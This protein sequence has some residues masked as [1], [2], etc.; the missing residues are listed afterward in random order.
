[1]HAMPNSLV[2][3]QAS[4]LTVRVPQRTLI[5][6][7][8]WQVMRGQ[9]WCL[10]GR[11]GAGKSSLLKNL[12]GLRAVGAFGGAGTLSLYDEP[13]ES[14]TPLRAARLRAWC[15]QQPQDAFGVRVIDDVI[16]SRWPWRELD[17][18]AAQQ[19]LA[20]AALRRCD[21]EQLAEREL[22]SLSGGERQR[23]AIA[24]ALAQATPLLLL[25]EPTAYLD[26]AHQMQVLETVTRACDECGQ[27]LVA[28]LHDIN[29]AARFFTHALLLDGN[30]G[31]QAG[32]VADVLQPQPL[33]AAYGYP[34]DMVE[35]A[36][37]NGAQRLFVPR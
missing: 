17:D 26:V 2:A 32:P 4:A 30:G 19:E 27:T 23:V 8:D 33:S 1:M 25:D 16:A 12:A 18:P 24:A 36:G 14:L 22:R 7:L 10:L 13:L 20:L 31:W 15:E 29:L 3:I 11:N 9:R 34:L 6:R 28:S 35:I 21:A 37:A 5:E